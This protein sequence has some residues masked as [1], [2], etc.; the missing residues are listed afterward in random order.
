MSVFVTIC[1]MHSAVSHS[2]V[3]VKLCPRQSAVSTRPRSN[4]KFGNTL[5]AMKKKQKAFQMTQMITKPLHIR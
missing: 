5:L 4:Q 2:A 1:E 3:P